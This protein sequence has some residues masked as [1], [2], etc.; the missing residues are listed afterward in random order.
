MD[1]LAARGISFTKSYSA[2]PVCCPARAS[3]FTGRYTPENG[4]MSNSSR[5]L[6]SM[7]DLGQWLSKAGY[8]VYYSGKWHIPGRDVAKSFNYISDNPKNTAETGDIVTTRSS[9]GFLENYKEKKPFF[10]SIGLLNPHDIC[11]FVLTHTMYGGK[12]P[13]PEIE[14]LPPLPPN[15]NTN[16]AEPE[17]IVSGRD[18]YMQEKGE[19]S[20]MAKWEKKLYQFYIWSYYRYI[21][22]VD[23]QIGLILDALENSAFKDNTLVIL[24]ADHGDGH[25]RHKM[26]FK[27]FLYDEAA[28]VPFIMSWPG[29]V[30]QMVIDRGH[31]VSGV[32][33]APTVCDYAGIA[34]PPK[35]GGYSLR[36]LAEGGKPNWRGFVVAH[37]SNGGTML[38]TNQHKLITYKDDPVIQLFDMEADPWETKN[39]AEDPANDSLVKQ[40]LKQLKDYESTFEMA[41]SKKPAEQPSKKTAGSPATSEN[42]PWLKTYFSKHPD[43]DTNKDGILQMDEWKADKQ[44]RGVK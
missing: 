1:R 42:G 30:K 4:M 35:M 44:K 28:R 8:N 22:K 43:A 16:M 7:P 14:D 2:N 13:F 36:P 34:P 33:L 39:L 27:S 3:W 25:I 24:S 20:G 11:S 32:D 31:L 9:I 18:K 5:L 10:F 15:F 17:K 37:T 19:E 21:E 6:P 26:V 23:G 29:H 41:T 12:M 38:R 40:L